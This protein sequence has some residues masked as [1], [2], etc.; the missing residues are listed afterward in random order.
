MS[1]KSYKV[2]FQGLAEGQRPEEVRERLAAIYKASPGRVDQFFEGRPI[3]V[4]RGVDRTEAEKYRQLFEKAGGRCRVE[5]DGPAATAKAAAP[6]AP[7]A[8]VRRMTCP[9]CGLDQDEAPAC[10]GCGIVI[11]QYQAR[12]AGSSGAAPAGVVPAE[13]G[14]A[15][16][17]EEVPLDGRIRRVGIAYEEDV[18]E[19]DFF[20]ELPKSFTYPFNGNGLYIVIGGVIFLTLVDLAGFL[21][22]IGWALRIFAYLY[23]TAYMMKII[24]SSADAK[25]DPPEWPEITRFGQDV[26]GPF[27][28]MLAT[29]VFCYAPAFLALFLPLKQ[30]TPIFVALVLVLAGSIYYPMA[31]LAVAM[32][33][34]LTVLLPNLILPAI[35]KIP[36]P[37]FIGIIAFLFVVIVR[38]ASGQLTA[39]NVPVLGSLIY[40]SLTLYF[41]MVEMRILGLL[42]AAHSEELGWYEGF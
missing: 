33:G 41:F 8:P 18:I 2:V 20:E 4:K 35:L 36:G 12:Q 42:H 24:V 1:G 23:L 19:V 14:E 10:A 37:Y 6:K 40:H 26:F 9:Q 21:G 27:F 17:E 15:G 30:P 34:R 3:V 31:L 39:I 29:T 22:L 28:R 32:S 11:D 16:A 25:P 5:P 13:A 38:I 7:A